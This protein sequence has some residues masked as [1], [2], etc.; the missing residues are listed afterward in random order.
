MPSRNPEDMHPWLKERWEKAVDMWKSSH[1]N[2]PFPFLTCT[3]RSGAEQNQLYA[4]GRT[5]PGSKVTNAKAG[6]SLHNYQ[7]SYAFDIAFKDARGKLLW[8]NTYFQQFAVLLKGMGCAWG[9][10]W[11]SVRDLPHF[12]VPNFSWKAAMDGKKPSLP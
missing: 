12:E 6:Q 1:P 11:K 2:G 4:Q 10:D 3:Y 7:P 9:G 8:D 5:K